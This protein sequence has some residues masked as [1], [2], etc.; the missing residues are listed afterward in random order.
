MTE[1]RKTL[2]HELYG[3]D[4]ESL[5]TLRLRAGL[6]QRQLADRAGT[7]QSYIARIEAGTLDPGTD[8][9]S[10]LA[11]AMNVDEKAA[12]G[13]IRYQRQRGSCNEQ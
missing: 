1:S 4:S 11:A 7:S 13:A 9:V 10:R 6:S 8:T 2:S 12:F 5:S 3:N